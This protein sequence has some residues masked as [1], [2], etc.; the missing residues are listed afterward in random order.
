MAEPTTEEEPFVVHEGKENSN[1]VHV[2]SSEKIRSLRAAIDARLHEQGIYDQIR[3]LVHLK[4]ATAKAS[5]DGD[6][7]KDEQLDGDNDGVHSTEDSLIRDVLESEVVQQLLAAVRAMEIP[8]PDRVRGDTNTLETDDADDAGE[9]E[10]ERD[11]VLYLRLSGGRAFVDQLVE[12]EHGGGSGED[13]ED[14][15]WDEMKCPVGSVLTFFRVIATFQQQRHVSRDVRTCVDPPFDEH[16]RF[17]VEKKR[18]RAARTRGGLAYAVDVTSPWEAL[19]LVEEPVQLDLLK[20]TKKLL[21]RDSG[22]RGR[23]RELSR[24]LL[25]VHR[26]DWRRVL[27]STLHFVHFPVQLVGQ[28]KEPVGSLDIRADLLHCKRSAGIARDV[29]SFLNKEALQRN[30]SNHSFYKYAKQW[31]DE[32]RSEARGS[33]LLSPKGSE[34]PTS[35]EDEYSK[36]LAQIGSR[37]RLVKMFAE[38]EEGRY[39]MVCKF[40]TPLRVPSAVRSPSEAARFVGLLPYESNGLVGGAADETWRSLATV[41]SLRKG[42]A[43]NHAD[44]ALMRM[45]ALARYPQ[46]RTLPGLRVALNAAS[47]ITKALMHELSPTDVLLWEAMTGEKFALDDPRA[48]RRR[49]YC[50]IDCIFNHRQFFANVQSRSLKLVETSFDFDDESAWKR[51]D[52]RMIADLPFHQ[53]PVILIAPDLA[54]APAK[55]LEWSASLKRAITSRRRADGLVTRWSDQLSFY[56]LPALNSYELER[57]YGVTQVDNNFFQQSVTNFVQEGH[58]FQGVPLAF[59]DECPDEA[60]DA[61]T[62]NPLVTDILSLH[63]RSASFALAVRC[64]PYAEDTCATWVMLAVSYES[65]SQNQN[66]RTFQ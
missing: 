6:P 62:T 21:R 25:A 49:G 3:D 45:S 54:S 33:H 66:P 16:F 58:T 13:D 34:K 64:F 11:V 65:T 23:W 9:A 60:L 12:L 43:Q 48:P 53:P 59:T 55:E 18:A 61:M 47:M 50:A 27:C 42:N 26:L 32:Y 30:A 51:M 1:A 46:V 22:N 7:N 44:A 10:S 15:G 14:T 36:L 4:S 5:E 19:C 41:L 35:G 20:V 28:M 40:I 2:Q 8:A 17:R 37:Q 38:D 52:E 57:L 56:L 39:R 24:E 63:A 31:W 29:R